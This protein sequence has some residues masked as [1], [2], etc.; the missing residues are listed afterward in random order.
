M[1][2]RVMALALLLACFTGCACMSDRELV[3][4]VQR[5]E[6]QDW[7]RAAADNPG[8]PGPE[9]RKANHNRVRIMG[10]LVD[11]NVV[12]LAAP[13]YA[14]TIDSPGVIS[15]VDL[16]DRG[17]M[18]GPLLRVSSVGDVDIWAASRPWGLTNFNFTFVT[19]SGATGW[20]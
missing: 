2:H 12:L 13:R 3:H 20:G 8:W 6:I 5:P 19:Q 4:Y 11:Q 16:M 10:V 14:A 7:I 1:S 15:A 18:R 9:A 17:R